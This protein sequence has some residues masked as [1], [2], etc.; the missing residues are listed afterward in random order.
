MSPATNTAAGAE[1]PQQAAPAVS[2]VSQRPSAP[3]AGAN[4]DFAPDAREHEGAG[5]PVS[6]TAEERPAHIKAPASGSRRPAKKV[7]TPKPR[8]EK[9]RRPVFAAIFSAAVML[10]FLGI[11]VW[12]LIE[13]GALKSAAE[14]DTGV[15]N[16]PP[17]L[18]RDDFAG[19]P[20]QLNPG[21]GFSGRMGECVHTRPRRHA[22]GSRQCPRR[23]D[24]G[25]GK[26]RAS[27]RSSG[28]GDTSG[29]VLVPLG[30][31][32]MQALGR[33]AIGAGD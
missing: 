16:P 27:N 2:S 29:E 17:S 23:G 33:A 11:G 10:S 6:V 18:S 3:A 4:L 9:R 26:H 13:S 7:K 31:E 1:A 22:G 12:W 25:R 32:V 20:Q 15:P 30:P 21:S 24:R 5:A 28:S 8:K 19:G 14:R